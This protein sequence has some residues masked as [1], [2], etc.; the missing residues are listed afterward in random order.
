M[1]LIVSI[2]NNTEDWQHAV[3]FFPILLVVF[4]TS[5]TTSIQ[6]RVLIFYFKG[7][8]IIRFRD[9]FRRVFYMSIW[10]FDQIRRRDSY[11]RIIFCFVS[12]FWFI[13][14][15]I[16][17]KGWNKNT[18]KKSKSCR[19]DLDFIFAILRA[20]L[21][22]PDGFSPYNILQYLKADLCKILLYIYDTI[23][24]CLETQINKIKHIFFY[25]MRKI[26]ETCGWGKNG[27]IW[28]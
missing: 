2:Y 17:P 21:V 16:T 28:E 26:Y 9:H 27:N 24:F 3:L 1:S 10:S 23:L 13:Y 6:K 15:H 8:W 20:I 4:H 11:Q 7:T 19:S 25:S 14:L 22:I 12:L 18:K 5:L